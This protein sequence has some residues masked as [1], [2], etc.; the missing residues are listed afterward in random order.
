LLVVLQK[1]V[2]TIF[3]PV[4]GV[5]AKIYDSG[6]VSPKPGEFSLVFLDTSD[7]AD[8]L[9]YHY[10]TE[11]GMPQARIFVK[12][13]LEN[14]DKPSVT[15]CHELSEMLVDSNINTWCQDD[16]GRFWA[17]EMADVCEEEEFILDGISLSD[18][19]YPAFFESFW[20]N[21]KAAV[22]YDYLNKITAPFTILPGGYSLIASPG[23]PVQ[24]V[25]GSIEKAERFAKED[26]RGHRVERRIA[27]LGQ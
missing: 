18:F 24:S 20:K 19:V 15:A 26:R 7:Q 6:T 21:S 14:N 23:K 8:A 11:D 25:F 5:S 2:D 9:G 13:S 16:V 3:G 22:Q 4:W 27:M 10:I 17:L 12:S 1:Y